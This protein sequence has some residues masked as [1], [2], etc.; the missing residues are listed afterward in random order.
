[1]E[2]LLSEMEEE[3]LA[4]LTLEVRESNLKARKLYEKFGFKIVGE[5]KNYYDNN[6]T[7]I[8]YVRYFQNF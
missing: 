3:N 6:E 4:F 2:K 8:L 5:R 7:A 1:M